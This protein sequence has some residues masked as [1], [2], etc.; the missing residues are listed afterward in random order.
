MGQFLWCDINC[1]LKINAVVLQYFKN[2]LI[3]YV[4]T[5]EHGVVHG[6]LLR[7]WQPLLVFW[8]TTWRSVQGA[9]SRHKQLHYEP[10]DHHRLDFGALPSVIHQ[11]TWWQVGCILA[12]GVLW[13]WSENS[14][15]YIKF[16]NMQ[17]VSVCCQTSTKTHCDN[18]CIFNLDGFLFLFFF[19]NEL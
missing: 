6:C 5:R 8:F 19:I 11:P 10:L 17:T 4:S 7:W 12:R 13:T 3:I 1:N 15:L 14:S 16:F 2:N 9:P 18:I